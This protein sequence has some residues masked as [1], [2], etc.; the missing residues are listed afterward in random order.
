MPGTAAPSESS[1]GAL[2]R[3]GAAVLAGG[4]AVYLG[5]RLLRRHRRNNKTAALDP[6]TD[7]QLPWPAVAAEAPGGGAPLF[8]G[9]R[10]V[11]LATVY[12]AP[13]VGRTL[14]DL[15]AEVIKVLTYLLTNLPTN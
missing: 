4:A 8:H 9:L 12:A 3:T 10:V 11:E 15:G 7:R 13:S 5:A 2:L 1:S 6:A 14:A